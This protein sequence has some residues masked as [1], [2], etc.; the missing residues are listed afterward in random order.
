MRVAHA[1]PGHC[2]CT[3]SKPHLSHRCMPTHTKNELRANSIERHGS[4]RGFMALLVGDMSAALPVQRCT[5]SSGC[6]TSMEVGHQ[7]IASDVTLDNRAVKQRRG[8]GER[9][10]LRH[11]CSCVGA[12]GGQR[13]QGVWAVSRHRLVRNI[14][15]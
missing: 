11:A 1:A 3:P 9:Q 13:E 14:W 8:F 5:I 15:S 12:I 10:E 4:Q 6:L 7:C 2:C